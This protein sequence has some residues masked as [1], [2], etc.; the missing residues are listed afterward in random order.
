M[1]WAQCHDWSPDGKQ[2]LACFAK[3]DH[4]KHIGLV[5]VLDGS[6][7]LIKELGGGQSWPKCLRF[8]PDG[9]YVVYDNPPEKDNPALDIYLIST[10]GSLEATLVEHPSNDYVLGWVPDGNSIIFASDRNGGTMSSLSSLWLRQNLMVNQQLLYRIWGLLNPLV[11]PRMVHF[12]TA[13]F[14]E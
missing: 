2:I 6:L 12:S 7:Q 1:E 14:R 8:S 13:S 11:L 10:D 4:T 9:R 5:S 3:K